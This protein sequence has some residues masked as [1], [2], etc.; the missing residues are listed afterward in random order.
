M[1][2]SSF[3]LNNS[4]LV[5]DGI[6]SLKKMKVNGNKTVAKRDEMKKLKEVFYAGA[7]LLY[8]STR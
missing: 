8:I 7:K 3:L 4:V 5:A 6:L 1:L 2:I